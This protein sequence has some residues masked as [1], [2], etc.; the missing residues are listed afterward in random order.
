VAYG[1]AVL[2][3]GPLWC[4]YPVL[5][6]FVFVFVE[7]VGRN[8]KDCPP[9]SLCGPSLRLRLGPKKS[10]DG[11][12]PTVYSAPGPLIVIPDLPSTSL[13][14]EGVEWREELSQQLFPDCG[15]LFFC[16]RAGGA[17][18]TGRFVRKQARHPDQTARKR[19]GQKGRL[20]IE[21][22]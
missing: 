10:R 20:G 6:V 16:R 2:A 13:Q 17:R 12:H 15:S 9:K 5:F 8:L 19:G 7:T 4:L 1:Y 3:T 11:G 18:V 14:C 22:S 21:I